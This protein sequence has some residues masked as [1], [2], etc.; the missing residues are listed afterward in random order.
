MSKIRAFAKKHLYH[1]LAFFLP[2]LFLAIGFAANGVFPFGGRQILVTDFYH[3]YYP[4]FLEFREI[5]RSGGSLLWSW[6]AG[7]GANF[8]AMISYYLASPLN[9]LA[10]LLPASLAREA[11]TLALLVKIGCSGLFMS[12]FLRRVYGRYEPVLVAFSLSYSLCAFTMGYYWNIM[13][14]DTF[15]VL[16]LV[17]L[18][19]YLLIT[20]GRFAL[21][22][23]S[24][25]LAVFM[26]F[27]IGFFVCI[28]TA[29]SFFAICLIRGVSLRQMAKSLLHIILHSATAIGMTALLTLPAWLALGK[30]YSAAG[31]PPTPAFRHSAIEM[32]G[33]MIAFG[34]PSAKEG[35][36]NVHS[37]ML[38]LLLVGAFLWS[39]R[40]WLRE[41]LLA[42]G[43]IAFLLVS[44]SYSTLDYIW[45]GFHMTNM[46]PYRFT[47]LLS[48][49]VVTAGYKA[50]MLLDEFGRGEW[51]AML[52]VTTFVH[53]SA[54]Y[55]PQHKLSIAASAALAL[56]YIAVLVLRNKTIAQR[57]LVLL[58]VGEFLGTAIVGV[59]TV[60][61]TDRVYYSER[62]ADMAQLLAERDA[63]EQDGQ[64]SRVEVSS[65]FISNDPLLYGYNGVSLFSSTANV[66]ATRFLDSM[67]LSCWVSGNRY[68]YV[69]STPLSNAML[70]VNYLITGVDGAATPT[71]W[72]A[73]ATAEDHIL[74]RNTASLPFGF[75]APPELQ[76]YSSGGDGTIFEN[77][78]QLFRR[79]T[80]LP[81]NLFTPLDMVHVGHRNISVTRNGMGRYN[82]SIEDGTN[83]DRVLKW[84]YEMPQEGL[85]YIYVDIYRAKTVQV[86]PFD[87]PEMAM[88]HKVD[89]P[90]IICCGHY[91]EG[92]LVSVFLNMPGEADWGSATIHAA[93]FD[94]AL[95]D[96]GMALLNTPLVLDRFED[97]EVTGHI[98]APRDG[99]LY[100]SLPYEKGWRASVD[101]VE[102][103]IIPLDGLMA[104]LPVTAGEHEIR[105]WYLPDGLVPGL[106]ISGTSL[107]VFL[108]LCL[109]RRKHPALFAA[110]PSE[111]PL[112][113]PP[114]PPPDEE[115]A[116][117]AEEVEETDEAD[118]PKQE[119]FA[120][121]EADL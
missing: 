96:S 31:K 93:T 60:Q 11:L 41:K 3:Q 64:F 103:E 21:Y 119:V 33:N 95:F 73:I 30:S 52:G 114:P 82:Y 94:S 53:L 57:L 59:S 22:T 69:E 112:F 121:D 23:L 74:Y 54:L 101:G 97:T 120:M 46:I 67:G 36:P 27:Y 117:E 32:L 18:G 35:L 28:F 7:I 99:L 14:Y 104:M 110:I 47:F 43:L 29:I 92:E 45:H 17:V 38:A 108:L 91:G 75:L 84:N 10:T 9:L 105:F 62:D 88:T 83:P 16:P 76:A 68:Y 78:N 20:E 4:F 63:L 13:W 19:I 25:A 40:V 34:Q 106:A 37:G 81:G 118:E 24:L 49:V 102:T 44:C 109:L 113:V 87:S 111:R 115:M 65:N 71:Y 6:R 100:T 70:N 85:L 80:G 107:A 116:E 55:G 2:F 56:G 58:V 98:N 50:W 39:R 77:Q 51:V 48:F 90:N 61:T 15:A 26:N 12:F 66:S 42:A 8:L 72:E 89:R 1:L 79:L 86:Y 5:V